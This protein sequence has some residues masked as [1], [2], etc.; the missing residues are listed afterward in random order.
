MNMNPNFLK[1]AIELSKMSF[2]QGLFPA[3]AVIARGDN[4]ISESVSSI[5]PAANHHSETDAIDKAMDLLQTQLSDCTLYA[6]MESCLMCL[7]RAYWAGIRKIVF[8]IPR[9]LVDSKLAYEGIH[10][11]NAIL[12]TFNEPIELIHLKEFEALALETYLLW[13]KKFLK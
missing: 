6:S 8:A 1:Q 3:G 10:E 12:K 13:E 5:W 4:V 9:S 11:T 7:S 2:D